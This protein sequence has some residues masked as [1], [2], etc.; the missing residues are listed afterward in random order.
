MTS[1][2]PSQLRTNPPLLSLLLWPP[3]LTARRWRL[4]PAD[5][6][7]A[8]AESEDT[9][10]DGVVVDS[11][12]AA[13]VLYDG[14]VRGGK[15]SCSAEPSSIWSF[16]RVAQLT[17]A[18]SIEAVEQAVPRRL[19]MASGEYGLSNKAETV[20]PWA[21]RLYPLARAI[22]SMA[23]TSHPLGNIMLWDSVEMATKNGI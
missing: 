2:V 17:T 21:L 19:R 3:P 22:A 14:G 15:G 11:A 8:A 4:N 7:D 9:T 6:A 23:I 1:L 16:P 13:P 5:G 10:A 18:A 12:D 20:I